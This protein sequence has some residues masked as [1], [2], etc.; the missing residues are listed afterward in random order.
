MLQTAQTEFTANAD[1]LTLCRSGEDDPRRRKRQS[2]GVSLIE[3]A[4]LLPERAGALD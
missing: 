2:G 4:E 3:G 1:W